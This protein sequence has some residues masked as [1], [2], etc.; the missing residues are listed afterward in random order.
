MN[1]SKEIS[2]LIPDENYQ[3]IKFN[4][5]EKVGIAVIN[6]ALNSKDLKEIFSWNCSIMLQLENTTENGLPTQEEISLLE[7]FE[8]FL[9]D[10]IKG[11][12]KEKPNALFF[13]RITWNSTRQLIWK[14]YEPELS[15]NFLTELIES[16]NYAFEFDYR[17]EEDQNWELT[18]WYSE[19]IKE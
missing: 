14:V 3:I 1:K 5:E 12:N 19:N 16:E 6:T 18:K 11:D 17:I 9:D 2:V 4:Q 13:G 7:K 8:D 15:N 10:K